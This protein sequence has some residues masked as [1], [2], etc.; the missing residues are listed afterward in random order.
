MDHS[1]VFAILILFC[2]EPPY[3]KEWY[4]I[5]HSHRDFAHGWESHGVEP[6]ML[7]PL[8]EEHHSNLK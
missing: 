1:E 5:H 6:I 7:N 3:K 2:I 4:E 8:N